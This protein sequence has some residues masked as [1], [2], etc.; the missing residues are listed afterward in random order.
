MT[1]SA[2]GTG[3]GERNEGAARPILPEGFVMVDWNRAAVEV[4]FAL[5][6]AGV[7]PVRPGEVADD[8][9]EPPEG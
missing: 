2:P 8:E 4:A 3:T 7:F 1:G 5:E 6:Q 9:P